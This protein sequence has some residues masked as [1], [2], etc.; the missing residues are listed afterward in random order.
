MG[1]LCI[2][3]CE[4]IEENPR[5]H[6]KQ[7]N[8]KLYIYLEELIQFSNPDAAKT[9]ILAKDFQTIHFCLNCFVWVTLKAARE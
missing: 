2:H 9:F 4:S 8:K 7:T 6:G 3:P 5:L 1:Y